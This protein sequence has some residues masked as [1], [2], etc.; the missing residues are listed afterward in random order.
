MAHNNLGKEILST[1]ERLPEAIGHFRHALALKQDYAYAL[2]SLGLSLASSGRAEEALATFAKAARLA[3]LI[4]NI[5]ENHAKALLLLGREA[6]AA[7]HF[8]AAAKLRAA[9]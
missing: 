1:P 8:A 4:P 6:E 3:P 9:R 7:E 2:N 5:R